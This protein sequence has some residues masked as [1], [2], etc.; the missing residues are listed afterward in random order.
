MQ[1][2]SLN[3]GLI[4]FGMAGQVFHAPLIS[5]VAG[6]NLY[7]V[8]A[9]KEEQQSILRSKYP[10]TQICTSAEEIIHDPKVDLVVIATSNDVHFSLTKTAL[11]A[12]K[13]VVV[14]KP[15]TNTTE[16]AD[17]LIALAKQQQQ[18]LSVFHSARWHSDYLTVKDILTNGALGRLVTYEV[19]YDRF[20]N[21]LRPNAWRE[22]DLPGSG[23]FYDLGA[24]LIDQSLQ[25]FGKPQ[26][27]FASLR[28]MREGVG[29]VDDFE[30]LLYYPRLK[31]S[32]KGSMLIKEPTPRFALYGTEGAFVK[33]GVDPQEEALK[34]GKTPLNTTDWG[35]EPE[36]IWGILHTTAQR[37]DARRK[38]PS[39][40]GNYPAYYE[41]VRDAIHGI[42]D[43][44][45]KPEEARTVIQLLE[46]GE[47][48]ARERRIIDLP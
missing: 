31:V 39:Q 22:H 36:E 43:L 27:L 40:R 19:R 32:L 13:H 1:Y 20:R 24:H 21:Y 17:E 41:N 18:V 8:S 23:I 37:P 33:P 16:E 7:K 34:A 15:F 30:M 5:A 45:V 44:M 25:L 9:R 3:I 12:G 10:N 11:L 47:Q 4:G 6:L 14:E 38:I 28:K 29:A 42:T 2:P 48:S 26:A 35:A 46:L